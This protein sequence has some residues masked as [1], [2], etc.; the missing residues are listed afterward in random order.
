MPKYMPRMDST[1]PM[2]QGPMSGR[3]MGRCGGQTVQ[4]LCGRSGGYGI[5]RRFYSP[6]NE[7]AALQENEQ[8]LKDELEI[9][10]EEI[11]TLKAA[12]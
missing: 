9:I 10:Q 12:K 2:G 1:G 4:G 5:G 8:Y 3:G 7:L 11:Q 6:R